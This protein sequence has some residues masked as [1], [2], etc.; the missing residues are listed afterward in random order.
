MA[1]GEWRAHYAYHD[2][3]ICASLGDKVWVVS[4]GSLYSYNPTD[5]YIDIYNKC[6]LLSDQGIQYLL[7]CD[8][9]NLL[10]IV[11]E[12][13]NID[14]LYPDETVVNLPDYQ[15][16][17][18]FDPTINDV[19]VSGSYAYLTTTFGVVVVN[20]KKR[21][22]TNTYRIGSDVLSCTGNGDYLLAS[23]LRGICIGK[24]T[25]NLLDP[26][27]W[28]LLNDLYFTKIVSFKGEFY[29]LRPEKGI[30]RI[31]P[32]NTVTNLI[33]GSFTNLYVADNRLYVMGNSPTAYIFSN[34]TDTPATLSFDQHVNSIT[35]NSN[36]W[37]AACG[38]TGLKGIRQEADKLT[39]TTD[40]LYPN[41]P[42][43]NY[44]DYITFTDDE[45]LLVAG[46]CLD[47]FGTTSYPGTVEVF[48][49]E[50]WT[51][52]QEEGIAEATGLKYGYKNVTCIAE[53]PTDP[54]HHYVA[55]FGQGIYEFRNGQYVSN[56]NSSNSTLETALE[57]KPHYTRISRLKYDNYN[58]L[59]LT[60]CHAVSPLKV[61]KA[62]GMLIDLYYEELKEQPTVT[63]ILF[64][65][66]GLT[67]VVVMRADA[68]LF[69][70][71]DNGTPFETSDD[72]TQFI[73]PRFTDQDGNST[74]IDYIYD[75]AEDHDGI[76]W[77]LTNQGPYTIP[78]PATFFNTD[79]TF[80]KIKIPR[81]DGTNFADYLLDAVY[82]TCI[83]ID[84][85]NRKWIG[86]QSSGIYL[87]SADGMETIHHFTV[88]NSPL[89]SDNIKDIA[90]KGSTGEVFIATDKGLVSYR[91]NA[92]RAADTYEKSAVNAF[93]NPV[94]ADY[95]G[96]V[97]IIGLKADSSVKIIATDGHLV[98]AGTS[99]GGSY[100]WDACD[101]SGRRV[102]TG[103]YFVLATANDGKEGVVTK[104][105]VIN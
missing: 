38:T 51:T 73:S 35:E 87:I 1:V 94:E 89:P 12:N 30:Y 75:I 78:N 42:V 33:E 83:A 62:D 97:T 74:T 7:R 68:G 92:T 31:T 2:A 41:S 22:F 11:Y 32:D 15:Q 56:I 20:L 60:N 71:D 76:I 9:E 49:D 5:T 54:T 64:D 23:T 10:M 44:C 47:Y 37:W 53:D 81:N 67:W 69:C 14:L 59:W 39:L 91:S 6:T 104:V 63:D 101:H 18:T 102:P 25:D 19:T 45:R 26:A 40:H 46:G 21:E 16:K 105:T 82:T 100:T 57:G 8:N 98:D 66:R 93:P 34:T 88:S 99:L 70:I 43:R 36:L 95:T 61:L 85:A 55:S 52:F 17:I 28:R 72:K 58:N 13:A 80:T 86:T 65:S 103:V 79:F 50:S 48:A 96:P 4:D 29:G 3:T 27:N 90:V 84:D 24:T 77:V